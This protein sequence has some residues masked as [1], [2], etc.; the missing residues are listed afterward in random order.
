MLFQK[1]FRHQNIEIL[2]SSSN[3]NLTIGIEKNIKKALKKLIN[4]F[5]KYKPKSIK[6]TLINSRSEMNKVLNKKRTPEWLVGH[7]SKDLLYIMTPEAMV[8]YSDHKAKDFFKTLTH[9]LCHVFIFNINKN[10]M[11]WLNEGLALNIASQV[12]SNKIKKEN[13]RYFIKNNMFLR[14]LGF[15]DFADYQGYAFSYQIVKRLMRSYSSKQII[16]LIKIDPTHENSVFKIEQITNKKI[17]EFVLEI[18]KNP[19]K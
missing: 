2:I 13:F 3:S 17:K 16:Q 5:G 11:Q 18:V 8:K 7:G 10:T 14:K 15:K 6:I 19:Q 9:E 4:Y 1:I 12:K